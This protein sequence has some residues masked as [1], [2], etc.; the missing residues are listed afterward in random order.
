MRELEYHGVTQ[1]GTAPAAALE[2]PELDGSVEVFSACPVSIGAS[3]PTYMST[4]WNVARWSERHGCRGILVY[5]DNRLVDPW[6][7]AQVIVQSTRRLAPLVAVQPVY[8]HPYTVAKMIATLTDLYGRKLFINWVAGGFKH[9][10]EALADRTPHDERYGRLV[11]YAS[12]VRRLTDGERVT[13]TGKYYEVQGLALRPP[14]DAARRPEFVVSGSSPAGAAAA[15]A[16]GARSVTYA[17]PLDDRAS[18]DKGP[19]LGA[20]LRMG[21]IA[22][23]DRDDAWRTAFSRFPPDREGALMRQLARKV[24]DSHWH[25]RFCRLADERAG[26]GSPFWMLPFENYKT[27]CP[28]LVGTHEDVAAEL[29]RY[30]AEGHGTFILD[31]PE[32]EADL[33]NAKIAFDKAKGAMATATC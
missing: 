13:V 22:R 20:G 30:M 7:V 17:L 14:V 12:I 18:T 2:T 5:A 4:I 6:L 26:E 24:S 1:N 28:Y 9:D 8:T 19:S 15:R 29:S 25:E 31:Q 10:L 11:E 27:M 23:T 33:A 3:G 16:L 21:I 32:T